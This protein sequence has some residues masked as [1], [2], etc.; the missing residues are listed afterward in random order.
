MAYG[1]TKEKKI[2]KNKLLNT[3]KYVISPFDA[4]KCIEKPEDVF[5]KNVR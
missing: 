4:E 2:E 5:K 3:K 1:I